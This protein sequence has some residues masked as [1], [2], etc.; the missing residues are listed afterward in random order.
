MTANDKHLWQLH[1]RWARGE[2][3]SVEE[4][5]QLEAWRATQEQAELASLNVHST[6]DTVAGLQAQI[7]TLLTRV[8]MTTLT[9]KELSA[10]NETLRSENA[11]L[12][13]QLLQQATLQPA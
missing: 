9:L 10:E 3:L 5:T 4:Q 11:R 2:T 12:R 13:Q 7:D 8:A 1:M 6:P